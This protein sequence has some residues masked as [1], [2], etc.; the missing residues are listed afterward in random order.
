MVD[1][2]DAHKA[3]PQNGAEATGDDRA[4]TQRDSEDERQSQAEEANRFE[5]A[6]P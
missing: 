2:E 5:E 6:W 4:A 3:G 1:E